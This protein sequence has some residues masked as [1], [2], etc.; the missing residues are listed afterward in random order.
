MR[1]AFGVMGLGVGAANGWLLAGQLVLPSLDSVLVATVAVRLVFAA[2][3]AV[4]GG[5]VGLILERARKH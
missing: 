3:F 1:I 5:L 4:A 2:T